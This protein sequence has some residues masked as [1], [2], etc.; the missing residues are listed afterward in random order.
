MEEEAAIGTLGL[1][2]GLG[3]G[4]RQGN[5]EADD[6]DEEGK[7]FHCARLWWMIGPSEVDAN[8]GL[9]AGFYTGYALPYGLS[10]KTWTGHGV[11]DSSVILFS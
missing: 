10:G 8:C 6:Q 5:S 1:T 11:V 9:R 4:G 2:H 3:S 7:E